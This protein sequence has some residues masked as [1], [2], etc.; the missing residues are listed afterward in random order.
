MKQHIQN[1][2]LIVL[3]LCSFVAGIAQPPAIATA[4][5]YIDRDPGYGKATPLTLGSLP[6]L[7]FT[8]D[9]TA[10]SYGPHTAGVR[11]KDANGVW[12]L[13]NKWIFLKLPPITIKPVPAI[14]RVEYYVDADPGFGKGTAVTIAAGQQQITNASFMLT[15]AQLHTG[16]HNV[17]LR[18]LDANGVWSLDNKWIF[19]GG[20]A[21]PVTLL[22]FTAQAVKTNEAALLWTTVTE[23]NT[24]QFIVMRGSNGAMFDSIGVV[25]AAGNSVERLNY[26]FTDVAPLDGINY[27]RLKMQDLDGVFTYSDVVPVTITTGTSKALSVYPNPAVNSVML[28]FSTATT[29]TYTIHITDIAGREIEQITGISNAGSN[30]VMLNV[31]G[32]AKGTYLITL[33]DKTHGAQTLKLNKF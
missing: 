29:A 12:G 15:L 1:I 14:T 26:T 2:C 21:L 27:Y 24:K 7:T 17:G 3:S 30:N 4:E 16:V 33:T 31:H 32:Y 23:T 10:I 5:Y 20:T 28:T 25:A 11:T 18:T 13:D 9:M 22:S 6:K 8:L 19:R